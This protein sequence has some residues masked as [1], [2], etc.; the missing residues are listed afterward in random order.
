MLVSCFGCWGCYKC[1][2]PYKQDP[3]DDWKK[4]IYETMKDRYIYIYLNTLINM[5]LEFCQDGGAKMKSM[6]HIV[7]RGVDE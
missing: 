6:F 2:C 5:P 7:L 4:Y 3:W 1:F